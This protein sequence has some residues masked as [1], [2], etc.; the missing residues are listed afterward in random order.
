M[1]QATTCDHSEEWF[2]RTVCA[3][4]SMH[5]YCADCGALVGSCAATGMSEQTRYKPWRYDG[6]IFGEFGSISLI[7]ERLVC[8]VCGRDYLNLQTHVS[9]M[10]GLSANEYKDTFR[11][12]RETPLWAAS[13][14]R[15]LSQS[16][17]RR[18]AAQP[19]HLQAMSDKARPLART[20]VHT[21]ATRNAL[22]TAAR[23]V[24]SDIPEPER[25]RRMRAV[26]S[27]PVKDPA[28]RSARIS[29]ALKG[30]KNSWMK[31]GEQATNAKLTWAKVRRI[32]ELAAAGRAY[33]A[34]AAEVPGATKS[35]IWMIVHGKTWTEG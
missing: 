4:G 19:G 30:R 16:N 15:K 23:R 12:T 32:R 22:A 24:A 14:S 34:I 11:L 35:N 21:E 28:Q 29:T 8:H 2:D 3:C 25:K 13:V 18:M 26:A 6:P 31:G 10:H 9:S 5:N 1:T 20:P 7:G 17:E 27:Y 33:S